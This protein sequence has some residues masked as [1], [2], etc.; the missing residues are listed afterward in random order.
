[1]KQLIT[2]QQLRLLASRIVQY[3]K[4]LKHTTVSVTDDDAGNVTV[5]IVEPEVE[6]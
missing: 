3:C 4:N 1:M 5:T 6:S 2:L